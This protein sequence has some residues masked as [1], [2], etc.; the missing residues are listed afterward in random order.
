MR[1]SAASNSCTVVV[2]S[3][4]RAVVDGG[5]HGVR[6]ER[7]GEM[8]EVLVEGQ[9]VDPEHAPGG[10]VDPRDVVALVDHDDAQAQVQQQGLGRVRRVGRRL[11]VPA[12]RAD[13]GLEWR[14]PVPIAPE[15]LGQRQGET[16]WP[17]DPPVDPQSPVL[18]DVGAGQGGDGLGR[19]EDEASVIAQRE[20]ERVEGRPLHR[21]VEVDEHVA[22]QDQVDARERRPSPEVVLA[23]DHLRP[24]DL[25]DLEATV[26][27]HEVALPDRVGDTFQCRRGIDP[28]PGEGDRRPVDVG[29]EHPHI[30]VGRLIRQ[31]FGDRDRERI[32]FFPGRASGRPDAKRP[33]VLA[34]FVDEQRKRLLA[35]VVEDLR[36]AEELR[37]LD[38]E[39]A[40]EPRVLLAVGLELFGV[41]LQRP[42]AGRV[43]PAPKAADD[44]RGLVGREV[45]LAALPDPLEQG[46]EGVLLLADAV[47]VAGGE[48]VDEHGPHGIEVHGRIDERGR[49]RPRHG[50]EQRGGRVLHDD[51]AAG[52]LDVQGASGPVAAAP[53]QDDRDQARSKG[54][55]RRFEQQID[56]W[57]DLA[58]FGQPQVEM[59]I[60]DL[61]EPVR[62]NDV[63][64][65]VFE[66]RALVDH[67]D[68]QRRVSREDL[69]EMARPPRIEV[70]RDED[71][72]PKV[73]GQARDD[74]GQRL[75]PTRGG[76][77]D[78]ELRL[79]RLLLNHDA[80]F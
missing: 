33:V 62:W 1:T 79:G 72:R 42:M 4:A 65:A 14:L 63:D 6:L 64:H 60:D 78:D 38:E 15:W 24:N 50:R 70:L 25:R 53:G 80:A 77:D 18:L 58:A 47:P 20:A 52:S 39:A 43:H 11:D 21:L 31:G 10:R 41:P 8:D 49:D 5:P 28:A 76:P 48:H 51:R 32:R 17:G 36:V 55:G 40:D 23:E 30:D 19:A 7:L 27:R 67:L 44:R 68:G 61:D 16:R 71:R 26:G 9:A 45:D 59:A 56:R 46:R 57:R 66:R 2:A 74:R 54:R 37:D 13:R 73:G 3:P 29:R 22:A 12:R 34:C 75:D 69:A 35:E